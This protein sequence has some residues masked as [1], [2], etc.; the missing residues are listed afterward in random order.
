MDV[1]RGRKSQKPSLWS[2]ETG[3]R[4]SKKVQEKQGEQRVIKEQSQ[5]E[6]TCEAN[7]L[8]NKQIFAPIYTWD[9]EVHVYTKLPA[10]PKKS[11]G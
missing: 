2:W 9:F 7:W 11:M 6:E 4:Q 8:N 10:S 1:T 3:E 5:K